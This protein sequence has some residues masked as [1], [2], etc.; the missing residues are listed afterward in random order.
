MC[1]CDY[2]CERVDV[3]ISKPECEP[4]EKENQADRDR[5]RVHVRVVAGPPRGYPG[6]LRTK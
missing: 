1:D 6:Q 2:V 5:V 3:R 4:V